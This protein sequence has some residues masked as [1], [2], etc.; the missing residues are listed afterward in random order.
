MRLSRM[1]GYGSVACIAAASAVAR[2]SFISRIR[3]L[4]RSLEQARMPSMARADLPPQV[5]ELARRFGVPGCAKGRSVHLTQMGEMWFKPGGKSVSFR[6]K[7]TIAVAEVGFLW[8]ARLRMIP[9]V[10]MTVIDY[11]VGDQS[12]LE[13]RLATTIPFVHMTN[14]DLLFRGEAMRYL[15]EL[16]WNPDGILFNSQLCWRV[17]DARTLAVSTGAG[18]RR[19]E[20]R[21]VLNEAGDLIGVEA[22][23]R[24][25]V[26]G[27]VVSVC[28]W[29]GRGGDYRVVGGRRIPTRVEAGW[30]ANG[31]EF[32]YWRGRIGS[33]SLDAKL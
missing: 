21:L 23:D 4:Q 31:V 30:R 15:A 16:M 19:C 29:F 18:P 27:Q 26:E 25:R 8:H 13:G 28:P 33:W 22:D 5:F 9:G 3:S 24:P 7:Q 14:T 2:D 10:S 17:L 12:G 32:I 11:V 1:L 20:V 6:A